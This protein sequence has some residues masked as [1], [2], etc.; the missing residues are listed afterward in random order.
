ML[1]SLSYPLRSLMANRRYARFF[2]S[3]PQA[4]SAMKWAQ[5]R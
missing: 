5:V 1:G 2:R 4:V 3:F